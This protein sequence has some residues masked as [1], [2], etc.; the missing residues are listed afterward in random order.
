MNKAEIFEKVQTHLLA[1][2]CRSAGINP[3][4]ENFICLYRGPEGL[5]CAAGCL[6]PDELYDPS[7]EGCNCQEGAV[8][9]AL[10]QAGVDMSDGTIAMMVDSLQDMHDRVPPLKWADALK[11]KA[12]YYG[13]APID[14]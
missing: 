9:K 13:L 6:I 8:A 2:K 10:I 4:T 14:A 3:Q 5:M 1:Q 7:M 12:R 11:E